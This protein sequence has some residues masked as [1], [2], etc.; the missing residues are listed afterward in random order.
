MSRLLIMLSLA[1]FLAQPVLADSDG[2]PLKQEKPEEDVAIGEAALAHEQAMELVVPPAKKDE[3]FKSRQYKDIIAVKGSASKGRAPLSEEALALRPKALAETAERLGFQEGYFY[4]YKQ[5]AKLLDSRKKMLDNIFDF[6][7]FLLEGQKVMPP[8]ITQA[9]AYAEIMGPA[10]MV[11][12]GS[13]YRILRPAR[14]VTV[15]PSW[16]DYLIIPE[17]AVK[18]EKI[19]PSMLPMNSEEQ[20]IWRDAITEQWFNGMEHADRMFQI[21]VNKMLVD[22]RGIIQYQVL[23]RRGYISMPM[24][25]RGHLDIKVGDE[26]L[27]FDQQTFRITQKAK[28]QDIQREKEKKVFSEKK[29]SP[30]KKKKAKKAQK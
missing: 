22:L 6:G 3:V 28:F 12:T 18:P 2:V 13:S 14:F 23:E 11:E 30:V 4:R 15:K 10:E 19:H 1:I 9:D 27:E 26:N 20:K 29:K 24:V 7:P 17:G 16:R 5:I 25:A 21:G 8:V